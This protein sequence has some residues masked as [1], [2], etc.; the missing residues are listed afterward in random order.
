MVRPVLLGALAL[1]AACSWHP[2]RA[3]NPI[4]M[5]L[6]EL[7]ARIE[8][9]RPVLPYL[10]A[11]ER[12]RDEERPDS[13][14]PTGAGMARALDYPGLTLVVQEGPDGELRV[15]RLTVTGQQYRTAEGMH[16]GGS[17]QDLS[18]VFGE[19]D[20]LEG[21]EYVYTAEGPASSAIRF[22]VEGE[23]ITRM[24]WEFDRP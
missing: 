1:L 24:Q 11:P 17:L 10:P 5:P 20:R 14:E 15:L 12:T 19:A 16:V 4:G 21:D 13:G 22:R 6:S 23:R 9:G 7:L 8:R 2:P 18:D 3:D